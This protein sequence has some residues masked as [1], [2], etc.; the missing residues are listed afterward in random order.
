M[1][2]STFRFLIVLLLSFGG[3]YLHNHVQ[4]VVI[5]AFNY[6]IQT[7]LLVFMA[8]NFVFVKFVLNVF[9]VWYLARKKISK[10][11]SRKK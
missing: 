9:G 1:L 5:V 4:S 10:I 11:F 2:K 3:V 6:E 7:N 8:L